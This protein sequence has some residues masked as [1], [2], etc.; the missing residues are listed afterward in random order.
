MI[1]MDSALKVKEF[2][3]AEEAAD[4]ILKMIGVV[5]SPPGQ[6]VTEETR[7]KLRH[8]FGFSFLVYR[9]RI[10]EELGLSTEQKSALDKY[11]RE[12]A[13]ADLS[14]LQS[15]DTHPSDFEAFRSKAV[16]NLE[17]ALKETLSD[18]QRK[19]LGE[20]VRRREG[21]FGG[22]SLWTGLQITNEEKA[23]FMSVIEPMSKKME[24][25][26]EE[27]RHGTDPAD[28]QRQVLGLRVDLER[29]LEAVLTESQRKQW[30]EMLGKPI[31][32]DALFDLS[33]G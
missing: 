15:N 7:R 32:I 6:E 31:A 4:A 21:L 30:K 9:D 12:V 13:P 29:Q 8:E 11:L 18:A 1:V 20:L 24:S 25:V 23:Q 19:R 22:P 17:S 2:D 28:F 3:R 33:N 26:A 5:E 14:F 10:Q 16:E 27:A